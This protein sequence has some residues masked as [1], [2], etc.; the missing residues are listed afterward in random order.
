[1]PMAAYPSG[2][3][4]G[5]DPK[6]GLPQEPNAQIPIT[7]NSTI[8][9]PTN[10]SVIFRL[11]ISNEEAGDSNVSTLQPGQIDQPL[12]ASFTFTSPPNG[13]WTVGASLEVVNNVPPNTPLDEK[14][15]QYVIG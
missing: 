10:A 3:I 4:T 13:I 5:F 12:A 9:N 8:S 15:C 2:T 7:A 1:M 14:Q 6:C 11:T